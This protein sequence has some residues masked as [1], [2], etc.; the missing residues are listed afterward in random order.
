M[1]IFFYLFFLIRIFLFFLP[2]YLMF[3]PNGVTGE[4]KG[5]NRKDI[6]LCG[7]KIFSCWEIIQNATE[8]CNVVLFS[9]PSFYHSVFSGS[10]AYLLFASQELAH[11]NLLYKYNF[12]ILDS[13]SQSSH[14]MT[15]HQ[16]FGILSG[17]FPSPLFLVSLVD[18][19]A[20]QFEQW[21]PSGEALG[22]DSEDRFT[23][24]C[25]LLLCNFIQLNCFS[26]SPSFLSKLF[27]PQHFYN[28]YLHY[29]ADQHLIFFKVFT[30]TVKAWRK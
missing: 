16:Q 1:L 25:H 3:M 19:S 30:S 17:I 5:R 15:Q 11:I 14:V 8:Y 6:W 7:K 18:T 12:C 23:H 9:F 13:V 2:L 28:T 21:Y 10:T 20:L 26:L 4:R 24:L 22:R 29:L 27:R